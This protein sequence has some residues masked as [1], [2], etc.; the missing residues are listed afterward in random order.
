[1]VAREIRIQGTKVHKFYFCAKILM[2]TLQIFN[3]LSARR[4]A[5]ATE[6][7]IKLNDNLD[8]IPLYYE[9]KKKQFFL[10]FHISLQAL[11]YQAMQ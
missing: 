1:M 3:Q 11:F 4:N 2:Q 10:H 6:I 7:K 5:K 9:K 8:A